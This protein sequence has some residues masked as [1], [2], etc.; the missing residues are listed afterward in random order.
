M[1]M[2]SKATGE[3]WNPK[4][5]VRRMKVCT[6]AVHM[7]GWIFV[8]QPRYGTDHIIC[9]SRFT[10]CYYSTAAAWRCFPL[11]EEDP[12]LISTHGLIFFN[13]YLIII[14][15]S[16]IKH[17]SQSHLNTN[18]ISCFTMQTKLPPSVIQ[19]EDMMYIHQAPYPYCFN[20]SSIEIHQPIMHVSQQHPLLGI[21]SKCRRTASSSE[22][23]G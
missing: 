12:K 2:K 20:G 6:C 21:G 14:R 3:S 17:R 7:S 4:T 9:T 15:K 10:N 8:L 11:P 19:E 22:Q 18:R 5:F 1:L 16:T 13:H 23:A